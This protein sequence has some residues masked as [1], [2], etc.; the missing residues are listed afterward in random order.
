MSVSGAS[1][2]NPFLSLQALW[3]QGQS[4][5]GTAAQADPM[6]QLL[7][8]TGQQA[9]TPPVSGGSSTLTPPAIPGAT[10]G[11]GNTFPQYS[12][13]TLQA[14]LA[15]Q[16][17]GDGSDSDAS[18]TSAEGS[19]QQAGQTQGQHGHHHHHPMSSANGQ[20]PANVP[21]STTSATNSNVGSLVTLVTAAWPK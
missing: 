13:Q 4:Q 15:L 5:S 9:A 12:P 16:S 10:S 7:G 17:T 3:Q 21:G 1:G 2:T 18:D 19:G 11:A 8:S 6:S 14:L 20:T